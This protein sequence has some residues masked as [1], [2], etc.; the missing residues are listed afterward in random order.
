VL[1]G[2]LAPGTGACD[3]DCKAGLLP[4]LRVK[5]QCAFVL[6]VLTKYHPGLQALL[7]DSRPTTGMGIFQPARC[8]T[9]VILR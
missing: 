5:R 8:N 4:V 1:R 6:G 2:K 3:F 9:A 7:A